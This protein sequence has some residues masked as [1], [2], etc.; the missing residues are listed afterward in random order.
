MHGYVAKK[1]LTFLY[2]MLILSSACVNNRRDDLNEMDTNDLYFDYTIVGDEESNNVTVRLQYRLGGAG[3]KTWLIPSPGK[4]ELDGELMASDSSKLNGFWYEV[5][6]PLD[7][8]E[9]QHEI[10]FTNAGETYKQAFDF[11]LMSLNTAVPQIIYRDDLVFEFDGLSPGDP[12][13]VLV[14]DTGFYTRGIDRI[15]TV[16]D[17][18]ILISRDDLDKVKDGPIIIE[19]Y[20]DTEQELTE[21]TEQGGRLAI[22]LALRRVS[23]LKDSTRR[24][25]SPR[26]DGR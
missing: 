8:F 25:E 23:E 24:P 22:S 26:A 13:R 6:K 21:S 14:T 9:G 11:S 15:D 7:E 3:G 2:S 17:G 12:I 4:V 5:N 18:Q 16:R 19:F 20:R 10:V 1:L